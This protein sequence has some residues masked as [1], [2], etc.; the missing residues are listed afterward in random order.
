M[1]KNLHKA[2]INKLFTISSGGK[3]IKTETKPHKNYGFFLRGCTSRLKVPP[4]SALRY[5]PLFLS[6]L[7]RVFVVLRILGS[8]YLYVKVCQRQNPTKKGGVTNKRGVSLKEGGRKTFILRARAFQVSFILS[9]QIRQ[10]VRGAPR[11]WLLTTL[12]L[13]EMDAQPE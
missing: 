7:S 2:K 9:F 13:G 1:I 4:P 10:G 11:A 6:R 3:K 8:K 12:F 5:S